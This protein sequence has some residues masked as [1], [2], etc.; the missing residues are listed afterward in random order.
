LRMTKRS[1][2]VSTKS[3]SS[4]TSNTFAMLMDKLPLIN[5]YDRD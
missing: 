1:L 2:N 4:S 3:T 5:L